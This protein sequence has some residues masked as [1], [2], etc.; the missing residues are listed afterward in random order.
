MASKLPRRRRK[1]K[2][3]R[4]AEEEL[5]IAS[6]PHRFNIKV[7]KNSLEILYSGRLGCTLVV[8]PHVSNKIKVIAAQRVLQRISAG[9]RHDIWNKD[10]PGARRMGGGAGGLLFRFYDS[11]S[12]GDHLEMF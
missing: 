5:E 10:R 3:F 8:E 2:V 7:K 6:G 1:V 11:M 4:P 9:H 12:A